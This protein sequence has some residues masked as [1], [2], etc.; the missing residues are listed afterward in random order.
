MNWLMPR[1]FFS[2]HSYIKDADFDLSS[3]DKVL[4]DSSAL[5]KLGLKPIGF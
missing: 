2:N 5:I 1:Y 3:E 4:Y